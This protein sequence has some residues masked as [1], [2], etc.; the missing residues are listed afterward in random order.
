MD[1]KLC[2]FCRNNRF[3]GRKS[4][5]NRAPAQGRR[6]LP[7]RPQDAAHAGVRAEPL[8]PRLDEFFPGRR[9][10]RLRHL[11]RLLS[12]ASRLVGAQRRLGADAR[13]ARRGFESNPGRR[14][15]RC[16]ALEARVDCRRHPDDRRS[17]ADSGARA[18][19]SHGVVRFAVAGCDRRDRHAG[20]RRDQ[21][22]AGRPARHVAAHGTELSLCGRRPCGDRGADG[23]RRRLFRHRGD[24]HRGGEPMHSGFGRARADPSRRDRLCPRPQRCRGGESARD[25]PSHRSFE[26][27]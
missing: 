7:R 17:R 20:N 1:S 27:S 21:P 8:R 13:R 4:S 16:A 19:L 15:R 12:R 11:R 14:P 5:Q 2:S 24:F 22:R 10:N 23:P 26:E 25:R 18:V 9:P 3:N 6:A